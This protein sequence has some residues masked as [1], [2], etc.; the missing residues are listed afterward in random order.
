MKLFL[1]ATTTLVGLSSGGAFADYGSISCISSSSNNEIRL[2]L[3]ETSDVKVDT[4]TLLLNGKSAR[5][6]RLNVTQTEYGVLAIEVQVGKG[7]GKYKYSF[8]N[9]GSSDCLGVFGSNQ[10]GLAY[11]EIIN[12]MGHIG[13]LN[14]KCDQ[15]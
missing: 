5:I 1:V 13:R 9:L 11:V 15:D 3:D 8:Q 7:P 14:C 4:S 2:S 10:K 12:S 6:S